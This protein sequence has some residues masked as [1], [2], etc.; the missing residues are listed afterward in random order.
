LTGELLGG[1]RY[2]FVRASLGR[3]TEPNESVLKTADYQI[4]HRGICVIDFNGSVGGNVCF[5]PKDRKE[6]FFEGSR[7]MLLPLYNG[8]V[9]FDL[10]DGHE[11]YEIETEMNAFERQI[12]AGMYD[13]MF[14]LLE[15]MGE[16][17]SN[18]P[19][20]TKTFIRS[21]DQISKIDSN[22]VS[23]VYSENGYESVS[24]KLL[25]FK[26]YS[27]KIRMSNSYS[28][29]FYKKLLNDIEALGNDTK[30]QNVDWD[31]LFAVVRFAMKSEKVWF[32]KNPTCTIVALKLIKE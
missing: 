16:P 1:T 6:R 11:G 28:F 13:L 31:D 26:G 2:E 10:I 15:E 14:S 7:D 18:A 24:F 27:V 4:I 17:A 9:C 29:A 23:I 30:D 20:K 5:Q 21:G 19:L 25:N 32:E 8:D 12:A 22:V 3:Y